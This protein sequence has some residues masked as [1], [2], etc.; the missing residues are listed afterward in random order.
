MKF[1]RGFFNTVKSD[2]GFSV[3]S[4][5]ISGYVKYRE[6]DRVAIVPVR[7]V[8]GKA[9]VHMFKDTVISWS[10]PHNAEVISEEKRQEILQRVFEA[11][12]FNKEPVEMV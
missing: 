9:L 11:M 2:A 4:L 7:P 8:V 5:S 6:G 12:R 1:R 10:A 3:R